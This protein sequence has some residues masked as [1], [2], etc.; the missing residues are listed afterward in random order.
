MP[1]HPTRST[2]AQFWAGRELAA[3]WRSVVVLGLL[4]G[5]AGGVSLAAVAGARRTQAAFPRYK[6]ATG[7]PDALVFGTQVGAHHVDYSPVARLPEV[8]DTGQFALAAIFVKGVGK[9]GQLGA[10]APADS[11]LYRTLSRPLLEAGRLPN[12]DRVDEIVVNRNAAARFGLGVGDRVTIATSNRIE[13]FYGQAPPTGGPVIRARVVGVGDSTMDQVFLANE[14]GFV[15]SG[16]LLRRYGSDDLHAAPGRIAETTNLV[17]RLRP[18]AD[19]AAFHRD[20][21]RVLHIVNDDGTV[22]AGSQVPIRDL[23]DDDKRVEHATDLERIGLLL[24]AAATALASLVLVGQ[25]IAR[26]VYAMAEDAPTV[27][28]LGMVRPD[29]VRALVVPQ[30]IVA[31]L[32]AAGAIGVAVVLSPLFPVGLAGRLDPDV[33]V[34]LDALVVLPGAV[35]VGLAVLAAAFLAAWRASARRVPELR[36]RTSIVARA[37]RSALPLPIGLGAGLAVDR[38]RGPRSLPTRP[39]IVGAVAAVT[40]VVGCFG[41]LHGIDD[42]LSTPSRS[43]QIWD[44][45]V[46]FDSS[47]DLVTAQRYVRRD[48]NVRA[49]AVME[50]AP[51]VV[52]RTELPVY[53]VTPIGASHPFA[54]VAGRSPEGLHE[55]A[56]GPSSAKALHRGIGDR[57][58]LSQRGRR[59]LTAT[60]TGLALLPQTPHSSFDQGA[61]VTPAAFTRVV[62]PAPARYDREDVNVVASF[63]HAPQRSVDAMHRATKLEVDPVSTP[64]DVLNLRNVRPLPRALAAFLVLLGMAA[65]GHALVTAVR[66]RRHELAVLRAMGFTPRQT[67]TTI[68]AQAGT[69]ALLGLGVGIPLGILLGRLSWQW[70][71]DATPLVFSPPVA[72]AVILLAIPITLV[73]AN[74]LAAP[75]ARHAARLRPATVLRTE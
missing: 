71:A 21:A 56:L 51:V 12:P 35:V 8:A 47:H 3:R 74:L 57:V 46:F 1:D 31:A 27:G 60:V 64:Q 6:A 40:G 13:A 73:V 32:G 18:G 52:Q 67:A 34:H 36:S 23:A 50:R 69:V 15:P 42:A 66:R 9:P 20:V 4:A 10:L 59:P 58:T 44:A 26:S 63:R 33:G 61:A 70:V 65:L 45:T 19:L 49:A 53:T 75:P 62:G 39:A 68:A 54:L 72:I 55:V 11:H 43:G 22:V 16:A 41:L 7:A 14:P 38:G 24:F 25:A 30:L 2:A 28:A 29:I 5:V 48:P 17:V 37:A